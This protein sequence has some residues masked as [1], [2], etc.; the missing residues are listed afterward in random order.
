MPKRT[1]NTESSVGRVTPVRAVVSAGRG[2]PALPERAMRAAVEAVV[3]TVCLS[4]RRGEH[5]HSGNACL[6]RKIAL[7]RYT[8]RERVGVKIGVITQ[9]IPGTIFLR[10]LADAVFFARGK[11]IPRIVPGDS[12]ERPVGAFQMLH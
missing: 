9:T 4:A 6:A 3:S 12:E 2:L 11:V 1:S 10:C 7:W 8:I 5:R